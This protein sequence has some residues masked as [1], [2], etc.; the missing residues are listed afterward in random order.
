MAEHYKEAPWWWYIGILFISFILGLVVVI[1]EN[2]ALPA[3][4]YIVA[5][6]LGIVIAPLV[7]ILIYIPSPRMADLVNIIIEHYTLRSL[8]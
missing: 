6:L 3:W 4:A 5:L 2:I 7:S 8:R 1:K